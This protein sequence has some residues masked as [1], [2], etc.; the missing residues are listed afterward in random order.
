MHGNVFF[1]WPVLLHNVCLLCRGSC[2]KVPCE[3]KLFNGQKI[4]FRWHLK[5]ADAQITGLASKKKKKH[6]KRKSRE[7]EAEKTKIEKKSCESY[8]VWH[9]ERRIKWNHLRIK[10][11]WLWNENSIQAMRE[12][13]K[14]KTHT[15]APAPCHL[16]RKSHGNSTT[17]AKFA[18]ATKTTWGKGTKI[19]VLKQTVYMFVV[20]SI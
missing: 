18:T 13:G 20:C 6:E 3:A 15:T 5:C 11:V 9:R 14:V 4:Y 10:T 12:K 7:K 1:L 8:I 16:V 19:V 17:A 2:F